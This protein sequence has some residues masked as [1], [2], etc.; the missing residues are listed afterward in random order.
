MTPWTRDPAPDVT[1]VDAVAAAPAVTGEQ[2]HVLHPFQER[3]AVV[4]HPL[5][6]LALPVRGPWE[7]D[8][9]GVALGP[10]REPVPRRLG[11]PRPAP[12]RLPPENLLYLLHLFWIHAH[13]LRVHQTGRAGGSRQQVFE[14]DS[15]KRKLAGRVPR[16]RGAR[17][18]ACL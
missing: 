1:D 7:S 11:Q 6:D 10:E 14:P 2:G 13:L 3:R 4:V 12:S 5:R 15:A 16:R 8:D 18:V 17:L 9:D